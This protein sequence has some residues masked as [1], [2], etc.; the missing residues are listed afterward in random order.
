MEDLDRNRSR[1][2]YFDNQIEDLRWLGLDWDEGPIL[3]SDRLSLYDLAL[4]KLM[5]SGLV[6]P[7][8]C[9]RREI[10]KAV[11][12]P[13][14]EEPT[15]PGTCRGRFADEKEAIET[16]GSPPAWRFKVPAG[17]ITFE[18][19]FQ[20]KVTIDPSTMGG[21]FVIKTVD[22]SYSY[23]LA[24]TVD[25]G[26]MGITEVVRGRDLLSS[27]PRQILIHTALGYEPPRFTHLPL[28]LDGEGTRLSKRRRDSNLT[29]LR[30]GGIEGAEVIAF[31]A[32]Q[33]GL[34]NIG[35]GVDI[36]SIASSFDLSRIPTEPLRISTPPW[37]E[38]LGADTP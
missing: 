10:R 7:C 26:E 12:A 33:S 16:K 32:Q 4:E 24:V 17:P 36:A 18:D 37:H 38:R 27:S 31:L 9:S 8:V 1:P 19:R 11:G 30:K 14:D 3:Q 22:E 6:Y 2:E 21:D 15:Y 20:G 34:G 29:E 28:V 35:S 13:H 5:E 25:D 23:Q